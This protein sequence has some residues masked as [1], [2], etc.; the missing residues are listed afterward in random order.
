M[1]Q[2]HV[3]TSVIPVDI[4]VDK[5]SLRQAARGANS[6]TSDSDGNSLTGGG[7][8]NTWDSQNRLVQCVN[9]ANT[10]RFS[11]SADDQRRQSTVNGTSTDFVL[12]NSM[13]VRERNH[14]TGAN[15]ATSL[16]GGRG[17]EYRR[18][19]V[20]GQVR[21][22]IYDG[23]GS[24][25]GEVDP[26]GNITSSRKYDVY[27]LIRG[28][29]NPSGT[30]NHKFVG[31]LGHQSEDNTGLIY[32]RARY[33]DA[34]VGRFASEDSAG[35][36]VNW[37]SYCDSDPV[38]RVDIDGKSSFMDELVKLLSIVGLGSMLG[39]LWLV[40]LLKMG[41]GKLGAFLASIADLLIGGGQTMMEAGAEQLESVWGLGSAGVIGAAARGIGLCVGGAAEFAAGIALKYMAIWLLYGS[42]EG[43][44]DK[45]PGGKPPVLPD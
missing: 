35:N 3:R 21:W 12:D 14:A 1:P 34:A 37:Y 40:P 33:Y 17:P 38:N 26:T 27:G 39:K 19:D 32:M 43:I 11:Y 5:I 41:V 31:Q 6:Y 36:G 2:I 9:G 7:R 13:L 4:L 24:V 30:S 16:M 10:S 20:T 44:W 25:L 18:N 8:T 15:L 42:C 29:N 45:I 28:G 23:H 22:Y